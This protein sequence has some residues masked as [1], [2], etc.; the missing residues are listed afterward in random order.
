MD[1]SAVYAVSWM[2]KSTKLEVEKINSKIE[3]KVRVGAKSGFVFRREGMLMEKLKMFRRSNGRIEEVLASQLDSCQLNR[4][5]A[6][7]IC[8]IN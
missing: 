1:R 6:F 5:V 3:Y 4:K 7:L 2:T 8:A